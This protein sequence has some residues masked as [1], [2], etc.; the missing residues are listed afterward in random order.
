MSRNVIG[1]KVPGDPA[2]GLGRKPRVR[3]ELISDLYA[4]PEIVAALRRHQV[5]APDEA[6]W[7]V[8]GPFQTYVPLPVPTTL[9]RKRR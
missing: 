8:T 7:H 3:R 2:A 5:E 1:A 4:D 9:L 6:D